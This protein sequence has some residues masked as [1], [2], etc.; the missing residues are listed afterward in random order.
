[1]KN[2]GS[3]LLKTLGFKG[4]GG[5]FFFSAAFLFLNSSVSGQYKKYQREMHCHRE[6]HCNCTHSTYK[7]F[8]D[9]FC[10]DSAIEH[11][12]PWWQRRQALGC[13][14]AIAIVSIFTIFHR[15]V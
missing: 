13:S 10:S 1:M 9:F 6:K 15:R 11:L 5:N 4:T 8:M 3:G 2:K 7:F 12:V 14:N